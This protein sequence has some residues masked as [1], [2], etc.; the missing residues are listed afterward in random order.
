MPTGDGSRPVIHD[1]G[2]DNYE[3]QLVW[4]PW[5]LP[6][7]LGIINNVFACVFTLVMMF[8]VLWPP[9]TPVTP[10]T[11]NYSALV[12]GFVIIVATVYYFVWARK[13]YAGPVVEIEPLG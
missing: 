1:N 2:P 6:R 4:G 13:H 8:F 3:V 10:A 7:V 9:A 11:M 5:R 12:S